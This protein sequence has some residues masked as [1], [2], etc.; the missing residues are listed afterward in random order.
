MQK[1]DLS[2]N[3]SFEHCQF[4]LDGAILLIYLYL[5]FSNLTSCNSPLQLE[6]F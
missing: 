4:S 1:E 2:I 6:N 3:A 5:A